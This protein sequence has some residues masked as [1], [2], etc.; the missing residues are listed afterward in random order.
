M[1]YKTIIDKGNKEIKIFYIK[2]HKSYVIDK[3][4]KKSYVIDKYN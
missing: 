3:K 4:I 2:S 1:S